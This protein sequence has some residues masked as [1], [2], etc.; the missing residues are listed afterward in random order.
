MKKTYTLILCWLVLGLFGCSIDISQPTIPSTKLTPTTS[1]DQ[2]AIPSAQ[3][4]KVPVTWDN[5]NLTGKLVYISSELLDDFPSSKVQVLDLATGETTTIFRA[6]KG[7][8]IFYMS[9]SPN[10]DQIAMSY[11]PPEQQDP[12]SNRNRA[13]YTI[14][15]NETQ[16]PQLL[17]MPP[18]PDDH[19]VH[20]EWSPDGKYIYY[21]HYNYNNRPVGQ[22]DPV[23]T[24]F[25]IAYPD[26][27]P[28]KIA[29]NAFWPRL[30]SDSSKLVYVSIDTLSGKNELVFANA[31]GT[32][33][34][35]ITFSGSLIPEFIDAPIF[36]PDGQNILFSA[37]P[38]VQQAYQP[39]W[40][41]KL[42]GIQIVKAHNVPSDWWSVPI[43]GG[44]PVRLTQLDTIN[45]FATISADEKKIASLSGEGIFIM[46]TDG[47]N[48]TRLLSDTGVLGTLNWLP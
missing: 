18:T 19:Y 30:S 29:D 2:L 5:L 33:P 46:N 25:R 28:E 27:Q 38:P 44:I 17:F 13:L 36:S 6:P 16:P 40:F 31:D 48:V 43:T 11:I 20:V 22:L 37:P 24:L 45:L 4:T 10:A 21:V 35:S 15:L 1:P 9:A 23:Y 3:T 39:N 34:Q 12:S 26:G 32:D 8:W 7:A 47:S 41:E 14:P 42:M